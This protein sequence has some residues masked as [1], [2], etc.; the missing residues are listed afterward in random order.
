VLEIW[1]LIMVGLG[2]VEPP[3]SPLSGVRS[4]LLS[5]RPKNQ[6]M[7]DSPSSPYLHQTSCI[8]HP[9]YENLDPEHLLYIAD[10]AELNKHQQGY[11]V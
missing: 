11:S 8:M 9:F 7:P 10:T 2:G 4:S 3:T 1:Y 5:Y 6:M